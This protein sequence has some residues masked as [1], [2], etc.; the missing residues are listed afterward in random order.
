MNWIFEYGDVV[1]VFH[2]EPDGSEVVPNN[3]LV[4]RGK[5]KIKRNYSKSLSKG[6]N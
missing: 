1:K 6:S 5:A 3:T 2:A 4:D